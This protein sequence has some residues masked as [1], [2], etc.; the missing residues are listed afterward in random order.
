MSNMVF[1]GT[2]SPDEGCWSL[3]EY[4]E[5]SGLPGVGVRR[6]RHIRVMRLQKPC[7]YVED[8][9]PPGR[10]GFVIPGGYRNP[11]GRYT[12]VHT[13]GE[14]TEIA[15]NF[16][17]ALVGEIEPHDLLQGYHNE[18]ERRRAITK[19]RKTWLRKKR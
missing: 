11:Q 17:P 13:V 9:G 15:E 6:F 19:G 18:M 14:L 10:P 2:V 1:V 3:A 5:Q 8:I 12:I 4:D 7:D 16:K